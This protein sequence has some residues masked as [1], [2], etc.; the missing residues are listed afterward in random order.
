MDSLKKEIDLIAKTLSYESTVLGPCVFCH[1]FKIPEV[2]CYLIINNFIYTMET[3]RIKP[4]ESRQ[5][6][7]K[8]ALRPLNYKCK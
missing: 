4:I 2:I 6:L 3:I 8:K 1:T 7:I 5:M